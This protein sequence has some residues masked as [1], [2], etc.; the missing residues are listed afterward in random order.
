MNSLLIY[1]QNVANQLA[2]DFAE[3]L[4]ESYKFQIGKQELL[5]PNFSVDEK[6]NDMLVG[7]ANGI[8]S[9]KYDVIFIPFSLSDENYTE[10]IGLRLAFHIRLTPSFKNLQTPIVFYG[11]DEAVEVNKLSELGSILFSKN[12]FTTA[13]ISIEDFGNQIEYIK[14]NHKEIAD[15]VFLKHF[16]NRNT[17]TP[18]G[19]YATHHSIT[20]E[21]S[22]YRWA[23]ALKIE[24]EQIKKIEKNIGGNL[25]FKYLKAKYPVKEATGYINRLA[26]WDKGRILFIEDEIEKGW[27][28]IFKNV[29]QGWDIVSRNILNEKIKYKSF[30]AAFKNWDSQTI[31][32]KTVEK[33]VAFNPDVVILD[34][35]L[36]DDDFDVLKPEDVTGYKI[37]KKIKEINQGIQV[38]ILSATNKI[39]N[40]SE[41]QKAGADGFIMKESPE[42][43][44]DEDFSKNEIEH[45]YKEIDDKLK[46][47]KKIMKLHNQITD[48][49]DLINKTN[50]FDD[51][52][53][54][55]VARNMEIAY[56]LACDSFEI[57]KKYINY[58]Y[59]Q[60]FLSI[61]EYLK[62]PNVFVEGDNSYVINGEKK[63]LVRAKKDDYDYDSAIKFDK[64]DET[65]NYK[66]YFFEKTEITNYRKT[67]IEI[68]YKM[69]AVLMF[70]YGFQNSAE[71]KNNC[72]WSSI[73]NIRNQ[74]AAHLVKGS[75]VTFEEIDKLMDFMLFIFNPQNMKDVDMNKA[76]PEPT[77]EKH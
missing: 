73:N 66:C 40:F 55:S 56:K 2:I 15:D 16:L 71:R 57:D 63:Y 9:R 74:K 34:F 1:N 58:A 65:V 38:I 3:K 8:E 69:S 43:S 24:N 50:E 62:Q 19:N 6:I 17:I 33:V 30:G 51:D 22:I 70:K 48:I 68:D 59:L 29:C 49:K 26:N 28:S 45:I 31:I 23:K 47:A 72:Y 36:H 5:K 44:I 7:K 60:F 11:Y 25:Y 13:K 27:D 54:E 64:I 32:D 41:L 21:W 67:F 75:L 35:R 46:R 39:W 14:K 61:E 12:I 76:L 52:F 18:S 37:L 4:G 53:T 77:M 20:N 42:L 10:F